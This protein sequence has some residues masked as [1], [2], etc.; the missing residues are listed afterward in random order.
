MAGRDVTAMV[1][2]GVAAHAQKAGML[3]RTIIVQGVGHPALAR[4]R[5]GRIMARR[6]V[7]AAFQRVD[8][9]AGFGQ[10]SNRQFHMLRLARMRGAGQ[11][12]FAITE[13]I[14]VG[15]AALDQR[16]RLDCL[17]RRARKDGMGGVA[18]LQHR[19]AIAVQHRNRTA[20]GAFDDS[21]AQHFDQ[22][23][24]GHESLEQAVLSARGSGSVVRSQPGSMGTA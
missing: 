21:A 16:Q 2:A 19:A 10:H 18:D 20:M 17:H 3:A 6:P 22:N 7:R 5:D 11:R 23:R 14:G 13:A 4:Q 8:V 24:I 9:E 1:D 15:R 12:Q